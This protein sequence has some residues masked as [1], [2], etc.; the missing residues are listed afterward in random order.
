MYHSVSCARGLYLKNHNSMDA[1]ASITLQV[2]V[3]DVWDW[4][5]YLFT[6]QGKGSTRSRVLTEHVP[7][8]GD[9]QWDENCELWIIIVVCFDVSNIL[10]IVV[11]SKLTDTSSSLLVIVQH[12]TRL[13]GNG[14]IT[15]YLYVSSL[16]WYSTFLDVIGKVEI[17]LDQARRT[18]GHQWFA[19]KKKKDD[20][21]YR[22]L[23][24]LW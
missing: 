18:G 10:C 8:E 16:I 17:P 24:C 2:S 22:W 19:L 7:T 14:E 12:K 13:G 4:M 3:L 11:F 5:S 9:C 1:F 6:F 15:V 20:D 23:H 21:K